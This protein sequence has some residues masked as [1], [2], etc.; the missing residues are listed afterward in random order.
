VKVRDLFADG[1]K[2]PERIRTVVDDEYLADLAAAVSGELGGQ[3][4]VSPRLFLKKLI[5]DVLDRVELFDDF[6]PREHYKLTV[7]DADLTAGE[8]NARSGKS[9]DDIELD[10]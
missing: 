1:A 4:G 5:A 3:V 7:S 8:R 10:V 9:A 6:D 2:D